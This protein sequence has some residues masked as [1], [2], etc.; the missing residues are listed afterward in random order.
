VGNGS[1]LGRAGLT[2]RT[3]GL[4]AAALLALGAC[5]SDPADPGRAPGDPTVSAASPDPASPTA[6]SSAAPTTSA[7]R[8][9]VGV[10]VTYSAWNAIESR[11]EVSAFAQSFEPSGG[12]CT[13]R[14]SMG[15]TT[16]SVQNP[17]TAGAS[18]ME[19]GRL[20]V[21]GADLAPG[22]WTGVIT[23]TAQSSEGTSTPFAVEV[24]G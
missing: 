8:T 5:A 15:A 20:V 16:R 10:V 3:F 24:R 17:A 14:L 22:V 4:A 6:G 19:C 1:M 23:F 18:T 7:P 9:Q 21:A 2:A 11:V 13:L 12:L